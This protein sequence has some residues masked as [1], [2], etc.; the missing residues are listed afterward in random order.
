VRYEVHAKSAMLPESRR[1]S[2]SAAHRRY[3][4]SHDS[5]W[6][7]LS[8]ASKASQGFDTTASVGVPTESGHDAHSRGTGS[9]VLTTGEGSEVSRLVMRFK[10]RSQT[11]YSVHSE[12]AIRTGD[13]KRIHL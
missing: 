12:S 3:A 9:A 2:L 6:S 13:V 5:R 7:P 10:E 11:H 8:Q 4:Q 1:L